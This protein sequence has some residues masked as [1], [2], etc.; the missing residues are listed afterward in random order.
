MKRDKTSSKESKR[1]GDEDLDAMRD[2]FRRHQERAKGGGAG[3]NDWDK[4][5]D[6]KNNRFILKRPGERKFYTEGWTHFS[7]G[8][9]ARAI[10]CVDEEHIDPDRGLPVSGTKCPLCKKF[11]REQA[12]INSEYEKGDEDG[13]AEWKRAKDK[14]VPR[15][16]Y[17]VNA[18][19]VD[20]DDDHVVKIIAFGPQVWGQLMNYYLG[21]DTSVGDF[22]DLKSGRWMNIKKESKGGRNRRNVEYKVY[23][24]SE[25]TDI[26]DAWDSI[27]DAL[28]DL[29]AAVGKVMSV[30]EVVAIMKGVD[31]DKES[32]DDDDDDDDG[33]RSNR[34][35]GSDDDDDDD[36]AS[37]SGSDDDDDRPIKASK[38][39]LTSKLKSRSR[40]R[41]ES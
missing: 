27:K 14:Y 15:H 39:K 25:T 34:R 10:R 7:V 18:L 17:Y 6:G 38:S 24:A 11:L 22:T 13:R 41:A 5:G 40:V 37:D 9:N 16:Q 31:P 4:L 32:A 1:R 30:D 3:K 35:R 29:D 12:R 8:P 21:D 19:L 28:H 20:D 23:P 36:G 26:S 33:G 2:A